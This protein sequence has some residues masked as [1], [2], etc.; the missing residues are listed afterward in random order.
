MGNSVGEYGQVVAVAFGIGALA[1]RSVTAFTVLKLVGGAY[2]IYLGAKTFRQRSSLSATFV[3]VPEWRPDHLAFAQGLT[4]GVTNPKTVI[5]LAAILPQFVSRTA[6]HVSAQ[7][8][9]LGLV[10]SV[11]AIVSDTAWALAAARTRSWFAH[12]PRRL[13]LVGGAG[14]LAIAAVGASLLASGRKD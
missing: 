3:A 11:I 4:V 7:I 14:G 2:L 6:E 8:L 9:L 12:S 13:R 10:F 5:F 1:E